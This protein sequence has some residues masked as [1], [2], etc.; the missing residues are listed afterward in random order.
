MQADQCWVRGPLLLLLGNG[1]FERWAPWA[2]IGIATAGTATEQFVGLGKPA[3]SLPGPGPQFTLGFAQRQSRL[4]GGAVQVCANETELTQHLEALLEN[5]AK[6]QLLGQ[7][8]RQ[9]MGSSG[10]SK[11]IARAV[12]RALNPGG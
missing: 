9:R 1:Q 5:H 7:R 3:L 12:I 11:A 8:G 6:C 4:L 2:E 10:G